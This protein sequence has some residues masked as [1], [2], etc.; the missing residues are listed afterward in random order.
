MVLEET[1]LNRGRVVGLGSLNQ[2]N[3]YSYSGPS[4]NSEIFAELEEKVK[5]ILALKEQNKKILDFMR[6]KFS[7]FPDDL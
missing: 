2:S 1:P 7:D 4:R 6:S 5:E 3:R